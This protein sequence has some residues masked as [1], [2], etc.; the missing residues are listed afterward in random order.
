MVLD[1]KISEW[2]EVYDVEKIRELKKRTTADR[3]RKA[4]GVVR[5]GRWKKNSE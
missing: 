3:A 5:W 4:W 1:G 2:D